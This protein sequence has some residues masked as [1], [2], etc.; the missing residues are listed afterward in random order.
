MSESTDLLTTEEVA[1]RLRVGVETI[2]RYLRSGMLPGI[3]L[4]KY[5]RIRK[6]DLEA[7]L[8]ARTR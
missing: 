3:R 8:I 1:A 6:A 7:F 2:W 4:G 5:W